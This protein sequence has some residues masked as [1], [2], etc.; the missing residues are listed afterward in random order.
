MGFRTFV[1]LSAVEALSGDADAPAG[2]LQPIASAV[3]IANRRK[4][5][6]QG[7]PNQVVSSTV[8]C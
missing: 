8:L 5:Q 3:D 4:L 2:R 1:R 7:V 6:A